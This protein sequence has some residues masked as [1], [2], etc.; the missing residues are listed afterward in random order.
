MY[1]MQFYF[2]VPLPFIVGLAAIGYMYLLNLLA[3]IIQ[4][5]SLC[6]DRDFANWLSARSH[7]LVVVFVNIIGFLICH[8]F[9]NILF[10]KLF[11]LDIFTAK[12]DSTSKFKVMNVF[13]FLSL[14]H[15]GAAIFAAVVAVISAEHST[16]LF[17]ACIDVIVVTSVNV[18]FAFFNVL[19]P[20]DYFYEKTTDGFELKKRI[21]VDDDF[22]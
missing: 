21:N 8:K 13:S 19:K 1:F 11:N 5:C 22:Y 10:S 15:S 17:Y 7:K 14:L 2:T 3:L 18:I 12:L 16:Q 20:K 4:N 9:R 6:Y